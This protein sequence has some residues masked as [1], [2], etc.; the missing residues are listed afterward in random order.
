MTGTIKHT[1]TNYN[2]RIPRF[3]M[4]G[5]GRELERNFDILDAA[6]F[7][8]SAFGGIVGTWI[9][10]NA[11]DAGNRVVDPTD[12]TIWQA[13]V[14]HVSA[15]TGTFA[16]D[17]TANPSY[18]T[19]ISSSFNYR[20]TWVTA[21]NY[22]VNDVVSLGYHW[23]IAS[24]TF[25]SSAAFAT[26]ITNGD[27]ITIID[28]TNAVTDTNTARTQA[29]TAATN[30]ATSE[31][32]AANSATSAN[33]SKIAAATSETNAAGSANAAAA[34][35]VLAANTVPNNVSGAVRTDTVQAFTEAQQD[36]ARANLGA[37]TLAGFRNKI[38]NG[39]FDIWQRGN[40]QT[41]AGYGSD[42]R[43]NNNHTGS[44]KVH[45]RQTFTLGQ[46]DVIGGPTSY[47]RT[48]VTSVAGAGNFCCKQQPIEN[49]ALLAGELVTITFYAKADASK[50]MS[51]ELA[52]VFGTGGSPSTDVTGLTTKVNLTTAWQ[53]FSFPQQIPP[54]SGKTLGSNNN[55]YTLLSFW[56]D[57]GST[58]STRTLTLGQQSGTFEIAH[59]SIVKRDATKEIDPFSPRH[60]SQEEI[61][62]R[63]YYEVNAN[64]WIGDG[65]NGGTY[66]AY[67]SW[68]VQKRTTPSITIVSQS[69]IANGGM[70][71]RAIG[72]NTPEGYVAFAT[73][74]AVSG[75]SR[76][77]Y[78]IWAGSAEY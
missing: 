36:Q 27:L 61:L 22:I 19:Q 2:L 7:A 71:A 73:M 49:V 66:G 46:T 41:T 20:G 21:T 45:S 6:L 59:V 74:S 4:S 58:Y 40:S 55:D 30:A 9:N 10:N 39:N 76:G 60:I 38:I 5:W 15:A 24:N 37:D 63:R 47:S 64:Y 75:Q 43:W 42:D 51:V 31:S 57:A 78:D 29:Q 3:D 44:T 16:D 8:A 11:Y 72:T 54:I 23:A 50:S 14:D 48:V 1:T 56:F 52:Q 32:N 33:N 68:K 70:A 34:S 13:A 17:R 65:I 26:D 28:V 25:T 18:W 35:A 62:A 69:N 53:K 12:S 77:F 67:S